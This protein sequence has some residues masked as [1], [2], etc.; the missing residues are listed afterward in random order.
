MIKNVSVLGAGTMGHGIASMFAMH[1]Y[2]VSLYE[3]YES[4]R[5]SVMG[6]IK[7][8]LQFMVGEKYLQ[9]E[10]VEETLKNIILYSDLE[11]AVKNA[12][13]VIE[14]T[15]EILDLKQKL[16]GQLD[17]ICPCHTIFASNTSSLQL[18]DMM[19]NLSQERKS[20]TMVCHWYNPA[21]LI[22]IA[23][24]SYFGNMS[25]EV[26]QEVYDLHLQVGKQPIKILK[27]IPGLVANRILHALARE[28]FSLM[29]NGVASPEDIDKALKFG[30]GFRGATTGMLEAADMG[31][32]DIWCTVEDNLFKELDHSDR[33]CSMMRQKV[34]E[35]KLGL[36]S[37]EGFYEYPE[38]KK[39][40]IQ[41]SFY[42]R[43]IIQLIASKNYL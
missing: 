12:D 2:E 32:L 29:E 43:L 36:K 6:K 11:K 9:V 35:G 1:G 21:H 27:D 34:Y 16:F 14:A 40:D 26:F 20:R 3:S 15:P 28:I 25:D 8:E 23:E 10:K 4:V 7:S 33:A 37:G 13:F 39:A 22:P 5:D 42:R 30:P 41:D 31:G 19:M 17:T 38:D 24:L 18:T